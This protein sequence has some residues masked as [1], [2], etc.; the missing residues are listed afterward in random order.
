MIPYL[1]LAAVMFGLCFVLD[2][3]FTKL[4]RSRKEHRSGLAVKRNKRSAVLGLFLGLIGIAGLFA[5]SGVMIFSVILLLVAVL[6]VVAYLTFGIYYDEATFL[7]ASFGKKSAVYRYADIRE[8]QRFVVQ[9]G[10]WIVNL[11]MADGTA[12]AV[13]STMDGAYPFLNYAF[14]RWCEQK[15]IAPD[16]CDF[17]DPAQHKWF[18]EAEVE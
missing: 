11:T 1:I 15:G 3:A 8:Q 14:A 4:F 10:S 17:H 13:Q 2:K 5:G 6:L 9:G 16:S 7:V 12:V 18:P